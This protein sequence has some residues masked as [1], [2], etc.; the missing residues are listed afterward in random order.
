MRHDTRLHPPATLKRLLSRAK[1]HIAKGQARLVA[2]EARVVAL[3]RKGKANGREG[4]ESWKLLRIM[5]DT[6]NLQ[7]GHVR[8]LERE[9][10]EAG[11]ADPSV[12]GK[13]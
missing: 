2:Q 8:L 1:D 11:D 9:V 5:R 3:E 10:G 6:Q 7:F 4:G 13:Q 12:G